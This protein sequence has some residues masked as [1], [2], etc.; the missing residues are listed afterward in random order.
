MEYVIKI[1]PLRY[2]RMKLYFMDLTEQETIFD[3]EKG[4]GNKQSSL[5]VGRW[6]K[7]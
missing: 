4:G 3:H 7:Y 5:G 1:P 6:L 2:S